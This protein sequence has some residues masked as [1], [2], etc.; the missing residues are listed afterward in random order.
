MSF[1]SS[2]THPSVVAAEMS[3]PGNDGG[4]SEK[5]PSVVALMEDNPDN[6]DFDFGEYESFFGFEVPEGAAYRSH[7]K[8]S[9][10]INARPSQFDD[11]VL[12]EDLA[13]K[14]IRIDDPPRNAKAMVV[15]LE[16]L[17]KISNAKAR[18]ALGDVREETLFK[19][20]FTY[21]AACSPQG[22]DAL[23]RAV[24]SAGFPDNNDNRPEFLSEA[25]AAAIAAFT[26]C[27]SHQGS[28]AW[29][30][31]FPVCYQD[32]RGRAKL[33]IQRRKQH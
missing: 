33:L 27:R 30:E 11:R 31:Y 28:V 17:Y 9:L 26:S 2:K 4:K 22:I 25:H 16:H 1:A 24:K 15:A 10:D 3:W 21:P 20:V 14:L 5:V 13:G 19:Y 18:E 23:R 12:Q 29:K 7:Y 8:A 32:L 6:D